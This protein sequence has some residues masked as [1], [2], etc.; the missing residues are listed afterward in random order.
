[1]STRMETGDAHAWAEE[2]FGG[3]D[4]G[5]R[6]RNR[7]AVEIAAGLVC[8]PTA[9][10][11]KA[12]GESS[13]KLAYEFF[14][15][16][17]VLHAGLLSGPVKKTIAACAAERSILLVQDTTAPGFGGRVRRK[18]LGLINDSESAQG[19][20]VHTC[21]ALA[22]DGRV[23]GVLEQEVWAR[24]DQKHAKDETVAARR[25]RD[26]ESER[27]ARTAHERLVAAGVG[28]MRIHVG[29][30][31]SDIFELFA[32]VDAL[33]DGFV[34][35]ATHD[36]RT[37]KG[38]NAARTYSLSEAEAAPVLAHKTVEVP[39]RPGQTARTARLELRAKRVEVMPPKV[40]RRR[41]TPIWM[42]VVIVS[43][44]EPP[45]AKQA[46]H[47]ALLTREPIETPA[48]V[49]RIAAIYARRWTIEDFH[50]GLKTG[51][52]LEHRQL[53]SFERLAN[54]LV[55]A[56]AISVQALRLRDAARASEPRPATEVL[57]TIQLK[58]LHQS[59]PRL[60]QDCSAKEALR[61]VAVLGGFYDTSKKAMPGWRTIFG[62]MQILL[63]REAGYL[64]ALLDL[65]RAGVDLSGTTERFRE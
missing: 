33:E 56:T 9:S 14:A 22:E 35:R 8:R 55:F 21:L 39:A 34:F 52:A 47:W 36:R 49:L 3:A 45:S 51:C 62:G 53:E 2:Q 27:W 59:A 57:S 13:A 10:L 18:G 5:H 63:D 24:T 38:D 30:R 16:E 7:R 20:L 40:D 11:P 19:M 43:E 42:N 46:L 6:A 48:D 37:T 54:F 41:G 26:R 50:M 44:I 58:L 15:N 28:A 12:C 17:K 60:S 23:L 31:E 32:E 65:Q 64:S 1:M 4:L 29:D 61:A 25:K